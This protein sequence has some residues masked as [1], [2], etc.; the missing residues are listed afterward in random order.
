MNEKLEKELHAYLE[1]RNMF[2]ALTILGVA[3]HF[4]K[5]ALKDVLERV[6]KRY[7]HLCMP[8]GELTPQGQGYIVG[9]GDVIRFDI[10]PDHSLEDNE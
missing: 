5:K 6:S 3:E 2:D 9:L 7:K 4:Y 1:G 8:E 10:D